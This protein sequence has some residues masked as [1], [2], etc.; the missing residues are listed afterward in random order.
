[1]QNCA[2]QRC[3]AASMDSLPLGSDGALDPTH[4]KSARFHDQNRIAAHALAT[5]NL[6]FMT[7]KTRWMGCHPVHCLPSLLA[8]AVPYP[9]LNLL[10]TSFTTSSSHPVADLFRGA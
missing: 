9:R 4:P 8:A 6:L 1:M 3:F 2:L 7:E 5:I 10:T